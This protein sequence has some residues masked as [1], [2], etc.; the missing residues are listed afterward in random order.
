MVK[1]KNHCARNVTFKAHRR[2][3]K[4]PKRQKY[5][6]RKGVDPKF[7]RNQRLVRKGCAVVLAE[8][9][10]KADKVKTVDVTAHHFVPGFKAANLTE[11]QQSAVRHLFE[12]IADSTGSID[13]FAYVEELKSQTSKEAVSFTKI[14][15]AEASVQISRVEFMK[16]FDM[17]G[18]SLL[19]VLGN[20]K[21]PYL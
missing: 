17:Y 9:E 10:A 14:F 19:S 8:A 16:F 3:I 4:G 1:Q 15:N 12:E 13:K 11:K 2:G 18:T 21:N 7:L 6:S 20:K 5:Q